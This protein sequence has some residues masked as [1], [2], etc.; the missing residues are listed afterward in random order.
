MKISIKL[1][2][3][4]LMLCTIACKKDKVKT[5]VLT[6][7]WRFDESYVNTGG[8]IVRTNKLE[9][10]PFEFIEFKENGNFNGAIVYKEY[11]TYQIQDPTT[12]ILTK[13]D[14]TSQKFKFEIT[15]GKLNLIQVEPVV[16]VEGC[17]NNFSR[18]N[19]DH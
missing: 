1:M 16:C 18:I 14:N 6:G 13:A 7:I 12:V 8:G 2:L 19:M 10:E 4:M 11:K 15:D 9:K 17:G 3:A 5:N